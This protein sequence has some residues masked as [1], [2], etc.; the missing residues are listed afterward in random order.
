MWDEPTGIRAESLFITL[1]NSFP[2][3]TTHMGE[4]TTRLKGNITS[5]G[6]QVSVERFYTGLD[7]CFPGQIVNY[8]SSKS[9]A[10]M[11][12]RITLFET[13]LPLLSTLR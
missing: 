7:P 2:V 5:E 13:M 12:F 9:N 3:L 6:S 10:V 4:L 1:T 11:E 8:L